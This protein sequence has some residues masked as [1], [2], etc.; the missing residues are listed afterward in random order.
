MILQIERIDNFDY[1]IYLIKS[2]SLVSLNRLLDK[3][4]QRA[5]MCGF[6]VPPFLACSYTMNTLHYKSVLFCEI[7]S[8]EKGEQTDRCSVWW[9]NKNHQSSKCN[10][11]IQNKKKRRE[12]TLLQPEN[13]L[14]CAFCFRKHRQAFVLFEVGASRTVVIV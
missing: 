2:V 13:R 10:E 8:P 3:A 5:G 1:L 4:D 9:S 6:F 7:V 11:N 14:F 12:F